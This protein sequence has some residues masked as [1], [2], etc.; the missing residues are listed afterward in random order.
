MHVLTNVTVYKT[1]LK[2][3]CDKKHAFH[4]LN[5][6]LHGHLTQ[7]LPRDY[8]PWRAQRFWI[9][10]TPILII[11]HDRS[12]L[13]ESKLHHFV[14]ISGQIFFDDILPK[15]AV[16]KYPNKLNQ[17]VTLRSFATRRGL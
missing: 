10:T 1:S 7:S 5:S 13:K 3:D 6:E 9:I 11:Q 15:N 16:K 12:S 2:H 8:K 17:H 4:Y 14:E